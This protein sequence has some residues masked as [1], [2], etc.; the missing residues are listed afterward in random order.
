VP[1]RFAILGLTGALVYAG[2]LQL[3]APRLVAQVRDL[4]LGRKPPAEPL[5]A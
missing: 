4:V 2:L 3:A 1:L 5:S